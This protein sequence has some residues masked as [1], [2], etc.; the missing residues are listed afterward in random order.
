MP[1]ADIDL[2]SDAYPGLHHYQYSGYGT[3][4]SPFTQKDLIKRFDNTGVGNGIEEFTTMNYDFVPVRKY[5]V[6]GINPR[7][8]AF[9]TAPEWVKSLIPKSA[10]KDKLKFWRN[11][12]MIIIQDGGKK[13][14]AYALS[15]DDYLKGYDT[16]P[17]IRSLEELHPALWHKIKDYPEIQHAFKGQGENPFVNVRYKKDHARCMILASRLGMDTD[18]EYWTKAPFKQNGNDISKKPRGEDSWFFII[19]KDGGCAMTSKNIKYIYQ[20]P[21]INEKTGLPINWNSV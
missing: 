5:D 21:P 14:S 3:Q 6:L 17:D 2:N 7:M 9:N 18:V 20:A 4:E 8:V 11:A 13:L 19:G 15:K 16:I 1:T 12:Y 10:V